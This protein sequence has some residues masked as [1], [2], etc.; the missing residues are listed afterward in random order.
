M[1]FETTTPKTRT[2]AQERPSASAVLYGDVGP[3]VWARA[4]ARTDTSLSAHMRR[5]RRRNQGISPWLAVAVL[6][7]SVVALAVINFLAR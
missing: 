2:Y 6:V 1:T 5:L 3:A 7:G 4:R